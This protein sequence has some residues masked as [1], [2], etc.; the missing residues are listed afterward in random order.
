MIMMMFVVCVPE[1]GVGVQKDGRL[2]P[3]VGQHLLKT[4]FEPIQHSKD[5]DGNDIVTDKRLQ[6]RIVNNPV[7]AASIDEFEDIAS[8]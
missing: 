5:K 8:V 2:S 1:L 6:R 4:G 7:R 3:A